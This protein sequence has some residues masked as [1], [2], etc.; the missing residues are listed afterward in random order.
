MKNVNFT[1]GEKDGFVY[2]PKGVLKG[3]NISLKAL[4]VYFLICSLPYDWNFTVSG[5]CSVCTDGK[6]SILTAVRELEK[7]GFLRRTKVQRSDGRFTDGVWCVSDS[8]HMEKPLKDKPSEKKPSEDFPSGE[9]TA[10]LNNNQLNNNQPSNSSYELFVVPQAK[11]RIID[12]WNSAG[13]TGIKE[14]KAGSNRY[15]M[16]NARLKEYGEEKIVEAIE[17]AKT[18]PFLKGQNR[19]GWVITFDW[20]LKP[21]NFIKVLEGNFDERKEPSPARA[22][23]PLK[24]AP[25]VPQKNKPSYDI[26]AFK[27][28]VLEDDLV[29]VK[30]RG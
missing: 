24:S 21:E 8:P 28:Q 5:L 1:Q 6:D 19:K 26:E 30:R 15:K 14:I 23:A 22:D 16:L 12:A 7:E 18:S 2:I 11:Q 20:F 13:L 10:L 3:K 25:A 27:R 9:N 17:K 4:G 29:Y